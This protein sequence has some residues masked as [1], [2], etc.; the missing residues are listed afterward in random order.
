VS[1]PVVGLRFELYFPCPSLHPWGIFS[2]EAK[3]WNATTKKKSTL[4]NFTS[5][6]STSFQLLP[7][8]QVQLYEL[9]L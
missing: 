3:R 7:P 1:D 6:I 5:I 8:K 9:Y 4:D 2:G